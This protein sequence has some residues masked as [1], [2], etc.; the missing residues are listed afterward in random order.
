LRNRQLCVFLLLALFVNPRASAQD[1]HNDHVHSGMVMVD[2][3]PASMFLMSLAS[4]TSANPAAWPMPMIMTHLGNWN[5]M[6]MGLGFLSDIQQSGPRGGDKLYSTNWF[7]ASAE[8]RVGS[9]GAFQAELMLS[10]EPTTVTDRRYPLLFQ[11]G[12]T[13]YG[14]PLVD[15]QHPHNFI[16]ALGFHYAHQLAEDA[17]LDLY[18][19]PVGDPALGPVAFPHRASAMELPQATISHHWQDSTHIADEVMTV[20]IQYKKVKLEA[21]GFYG[22]EPGENWWIIQSGPLNS[23]S[24]RLWFFPAKSWAA[25]VSFGRI[26]NPEALEPG[27]QA[28]MTASVEYT[29]PMNGASWASSLVWGRTYSSATFRNL[30]S[31]LAES[32]LPVSRGNFLTGRFELV[33]KD[34]LFTDEPIVKGAFRVGA[35]TVGFTRDIN[36]F[37]YIETGVG[38]NF[39]A[40]SFPDAIKPYYGSHPI[41][42]NIFARFRLRP[43]G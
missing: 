19:A 6:F 4:G 40:Y 12:E 17:T 25:Q 30:N 9:N 21:S 27:D 43:R 7:M 29:R 26:A 20:G 16:M 23:W 18:F 15:S 8:H 3:N 1:E 39:T 22:S 13:A 37:R 36:L 31:Y 42:G 11:T 28:R 24:T 38:A 10:L 33:D 34:E 5:T 35:Y 41:G 32:V 2:I 14:V